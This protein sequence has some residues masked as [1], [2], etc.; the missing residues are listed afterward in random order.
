[1]IY[2]W[3]FKKYPVSNFSLDILHSMVKVSLFTIHDNSWQHILC[4]N[5]CSTSTS[6]TQQSFE[7]LRSWSK[8]PWQGPSFPSC[9]GIKMARMKQLIQP[10]FTVPSWTSMWEF[11]WKHAWMNNS[12]MASLYF[13]TVYKDFFV[14]QFHPTVDNQV[15]LKLPPCTRVTRQH[16]GLPGEFHLLSVFLSTNIS[17]QM[18]AVDIWYLKGIWQR[19]VQPGRSL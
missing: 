4:R 5:Q 3:D 6:R 1:M 10:K 14:D 8:L 18:V 15:R 9:P 7:R 17:L 16:R 13:S 12:C 19:D 2:H 11:D